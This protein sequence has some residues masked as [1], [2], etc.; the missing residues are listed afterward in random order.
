[1]KKTRRQQR[2][3]AICLPGI[4]DPDLLID[5]LRRHRREITI[6]P[7]MVEELAKGE[8]LTRRYRLH[9]EALLAD[10]PRTCARCQQPIAGRA[11]RRF[12]SDACRI[13]A[14][15]AKQRRATALAVDDA[16][17]PDGT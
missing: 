11:D 17:R 4:P 16:T 3:E 2:F 6:E 14:H 15:H 9:L 1:M 13:A 5:E 12:C 8:R 7:W 10:E